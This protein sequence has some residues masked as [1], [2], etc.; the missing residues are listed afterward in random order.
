MASFRPEKVT[1]P[2]C[3][4]SHTCQFHASYDRNLIDF[5][6]GRPVY[7]E[8]CICRVICGSCGH[9]HAILPDLVIPYSTY[10]LFFILRVIAEYLTGRNTVG[11]LCSRFDISHSMLY[12]WLELFDSHKRDW[13]G[14][15]TSVEV[16]SMD[17]LWHLCSAPAF[18]DLAS[19]FVLLT[20]VSFLQ[21]H[22]NPAPYRQTVF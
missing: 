16:S 1:C 4:A 2:Y 5:I 8:I 22:R 12:R 7:H 19:A 15:L 14:A 18:S 13:L 20:S 21:S 10:G 9:T 6:S 3:G 11:Q 17:F